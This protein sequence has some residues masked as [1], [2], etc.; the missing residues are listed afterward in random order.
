LISDPNKIYDVI[1]D[2]QDISWYKM[3]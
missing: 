1:L 2:S 3:I